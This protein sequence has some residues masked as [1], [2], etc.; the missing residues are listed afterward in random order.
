MASNLL[1]D[2]KALNSG[3][4]SEIN[5]NS[6]KPLLRWMSG[7]PENLQACERI[8][9]LFYSVPSEVVIS[10]LYA[11]CKGGFFKYPK[12]T[13]TPEDEKWELVKKYLCQIYGWSG[14]EFE[15]N[16]QTINFNVAINFIHQRVG[17]DKKECKVLGVD[18]GA[19]TKYK[20]TDKPKPVTGL[21]AFL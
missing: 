8:E 20:F 7:K 14:N 18:Y 1:D 21:S 17:L 10:L 3:K 4:L 12:K 6:A 15:K 11:N 2:W 16:K 9:E 19:V 5:K 13:P